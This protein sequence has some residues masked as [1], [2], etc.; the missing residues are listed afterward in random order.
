MKNFEIIFLLLT[1]IYITYGNADEI[2]KNFASVLTFLLY[3]IVI[4]ILFHEKL[5]ALILIIEK[6]MAALCVE[7]IILERDKRLSSRRLNILKKNV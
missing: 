5:G 6:Y 2:V 3:G 7:C 1:F 4:A